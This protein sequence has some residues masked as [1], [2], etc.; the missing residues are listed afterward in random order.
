MQVL[1]EITVWCLLYVAT[2]AG[3]LY[4]VGGPRLSDDS[5]QYLS[6]AENIQDGHGL[7]TSVVHFDTERLSGQIPAP[8]TTFPPGYPLAIAALGET[9][10]SRETAGLILCAASYVFL[11]PLIFWAASLLQLSAIATRIALL[12][13]LGNAAAGGFATSVA[14]ESLFTVFSFGALVCLLQH[15]IGKKGTGAAL[16]GNFLIGCAFWVRYAGLFLF[17]AA[18]VYL[19]WQAMIRRDRRS[20]IAAAYLALPAAIIGCLLVRN[21][22]LTGSWKGGN[23]KVVSH[24]FAGV[25]KLFVTSTY[26]LFFG[27]GV[28]TRLGPA[29]VV[30]GLGFILLL[31]TAVRTVAS[32]DI[33]SAMGKLFAPPALLL[34]YV[35]VY[36]AC[37]IYLGVST[38]ISFGSRMFYPLLPVYFLLCGFFLTRIEGLSHVR[39]RSLAWTTCVVIVIGSYW[40]I[41]LQCV[42]AQRLS[43]PDQAVE[44][45]F[46]MP[47]ATGR[48]LSSWF[49]KNVPPDA[50]LV[51]TNGQATAYVLR[52]KTVSLASSL[53]SDQQWDEAQVRTV[54]QR[55]KANYLVLYPGMDTTVEPVQEESTFLTA[56]IQGRAPQWLQLASRNSQVMVFRRLEAK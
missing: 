39:M 37:M 1:K 9:G 54:M 23:T 33:R 43:S 52:R 38:V 29:Q 28:P 44:A 24:A 10:L 42:M 20:L 3:V 51:A 46:A 55:Y 13:L 35:T 27:E 4:H 8:L 34:V 40:A 6:E 26:H 22:E 56:L 17:A 47:N 7:K 41:N 50:V 25:L 2:V 15:E 45:S 31:V 16:V 14:T 30:L 36:N 49:Q 32:T 12:V 18:G 11:V 19:V 48:S 21:T 5:Y 53:F